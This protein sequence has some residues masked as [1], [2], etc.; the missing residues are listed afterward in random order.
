M[1]IIDSLRI[2]KLFTQT[3][4]CGNCGQLVDFEFR[5]VVDFRN[6]TPDQIREIGLPKKHRQINTGPGVQFVKPKDRA[7]GASF[8]QCPRCNYPT[9]ILFE[10]NLEALESL[11][12][13]DNRQTGVGV[14]MQV[15]AVLEQ[16]PSAK[17]PEQDPIWPDSIRRKF[18]DAQNMLTQRFSPS[19]VLTTCGTVLELALKELDQSDER[20]NLYK[21]IENLHAN[22]TITSPI[23]DWA[24]SIRLDRN[25]AVHDG[26]G[27]EKDAAEYI[28]FL[29]ML[30]NMAFSLPARITEKR[31]HA[32]QDR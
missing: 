22:G 17:E 2:F 18:A 14:K 24:H 7:T 30:F 1:A 29:K 31:G 15:F 9:M 32:A 26:E 21:R 27:D 23:K 19:I 3:L 20:K 8:T 13:V 6:L 25:D 5:H 28:E 10:T 4:N 16:Y 12:R 11:Q